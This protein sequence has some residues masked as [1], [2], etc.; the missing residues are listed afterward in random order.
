[1]NTTSCNGIFSSKTSTAGTTRSRDGIAAD[2]QLSS[3]VV[4]LPAPVLA[5][6]AASVS[7]DLLWGSSVPRR[8]RFG[9][10]L[11]QA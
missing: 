7:E 8:L 4:V 3:G 10:C 9:I 6:E 1:M 11:A 2:R 5:E